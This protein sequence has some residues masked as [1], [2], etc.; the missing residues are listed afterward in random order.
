M[1]RCGTA[2]VWGVAVLYFGQKV[3][4]RTSGD[5]RAEDEL[6]SWRSVRSL[7]LLRKLPLVLRSGSLATKG[8][9][10]R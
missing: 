7:S 2:A 10:S 1:E 8:E 9:T 3:R 6:P 4:R 5:K